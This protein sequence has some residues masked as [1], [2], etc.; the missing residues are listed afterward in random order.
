MDE[1]NTAP[2]LLTTKIHVPPLPPS[3][4]P[5]PHLIERLNEGLH[6]GR[7]LTL[8]SAPAGFGKTTLI[9]EWI[10]ARVNSR[11][12]GVGEEHA[13]SGEPSPTPYSL[14][15]TP[16]FAWLSLDD[17]D[18]D[19]AQFLD[20]LITALQQVDD[21]IGRSVQPAIRS[22][23]LPPAQSLVTPLINDIAAAPRL[24]LVLDD[25]HLITSNAVHQIVQ[26]LLER[27]PPSM[28][29]VI[30]SR[31]DPPLPLP[32]LRAHGQVTEIRERDMRFTA[33]EAAAF[34][35]QTMGLSLS[36]QA[37]TALESRT[38]GWIA[39]LQLA[40]LAL[41]EAPAD[42]EAF[43][44]AFTGS[45]RYVMDYLVAEVLQRQPQPVRDFLCQTAI[46][47]R[48]NASLCQALTG[49]EDSQV[50]LE[51]LEGANVFLTA[52]DHRREWYR[53]HHL[54]A[55]FLRTTLDQ[56]Q[57]GRLNQRAARWYET[58]G[59]T[60]QA[61]R[62]ALACAAVSG[63]STDAERLIC[64]AADETIHRGGLLTVRGWLDALPDERVR[65]N[66]ELATDKGWVLALTGELARAEE[67]A[68]AAEACLRPAQPEPEREDLDREDV[69]GPS[70]QAHAQPPDGYLGK[71][72]ALRAFA[73]LLGRL[74]HEDAVEYA[75]GAL[76]VLPE[77]DPHWRIIALWTMA[78]S[79]ER[80]GN[81][82]AAIAI[83]RE[84]QRAGQAAGNLFCPVLVEMTLAAALNAY[85]KRREAVRVCEET[86]ERYTDAEGGPSPLA[87]IIFS[88]LATLHYEADELDV[89]R[90]Y[91]E[92]SLALG[93]QLALGSDLAFSYGSYA[94]TLYAQGETVAALGAL[95]KA[96]QLTAESGMTDTNWLI[97]CEATI[98]LCEGDLS[99]ARHWADTEGLSPDDAPQYL[100]LDQHILYGRL[101]L[102]Q[103]RLADARRWLARLERFTRERGLHRWRITTHIL[104]ALT[105]ERSGDRR[106]AHDFLS[107]AIQTAAPG[108]Y[109]RAFLDE[110]EPVIDLL[111]AVRHAA[112][113]FVDHLLDCTGTARRPP[114]ERAPSHRT[115]LPLIESPSNREL[116]VLQLIAAGLSN[117]EIAH[118][119]YIAIGT[120]KRHINNIYGKLQ[121]HRRTEAVARA[122]SLGLL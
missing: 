61:I 86:I 34:L 104:Q 50:I 88:R 78:E 23:Q 121:V 5:R 90:R 1:M 33:G 79:Q 114:Q 15:P 31:E 21:R 107:R 29:L 26:L 80:T 120:V 99:F 97:A 51:Q 8:I 106:A 108:D 39:G 122:R 55:E 7:R 115:S 75:S 93:E 72:L 4:V 76:H 12:Q 65:A 30:G 17:G 77:D 43:I 53:Y 91:H 67:Y 81:I 9:G 109:Y 70:Q 60:A 102:A 48:M 27:Q 49:R 83:L 14:L 74:D 116:E 103:G 69:S 54:F 6:P 100:R 64:L 82:T 56:E 59:L 35:N 11:E 105:A 66:G 112:P 42:T 3:L 25:Y 2:P 85:G 57:K 71:L 111:P 38:E 37:V 41:Q 20:Y 94:P 118:E 92:Q 68:R 32:R 117:R 19:P 89:A 13:P 52:L 110:G 98:R 10:Q 47:D 44:A 40:A 73:A 113:A 16:S 22:A 84:A 119:L 96:Y 63:E 101:L 62:H 95:R 18:N 58:H 46:L 45:D 87:S 24:A 28:H 36:A